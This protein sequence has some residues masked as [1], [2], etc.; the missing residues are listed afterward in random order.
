[1]LR[2]HVLDPACGSG[3]FLYVAYR[4][5]KRLELELLEKIHDNFGDR[6]RE[7]AGGA[8]L[9][10]ASQFFGLDIK[11]FAVELA[12]VTLMIAKK[13]APGGSRA[14]LA[15]DEQHRTV[16]IAEPELPL[17]N[18]NA[19]I[20]CDDALFCPWPAADAVI[21]N[22]PYLGSRYVA[23]EHGY[24][25]ARR[26]YAAFPDVPKMADYC[27]YWFRRAHDELPD[28]GRAGLVGTNT[29]RQ[30]ESREASLDYVVSNGGAITEAVSTE[31][32]SGDAAGPRL[33]RQLVK[34]QAGGGKAVVHA[35]RRLSRQPVESGGVR[36]HRTLAAKWNRCH[37][38]SPNRN[39]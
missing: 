26:I 35:N 21:G 33:H 31:V 30:N 29:I 4:E 17:D 1:M 39:Q 2:Y 13:L 19:N 37:R 5:L 6:T 16:D 20:R 22:P 12:K 9:V 32:W 36:L 27:V 11:P 3:N 14:R 38:R 28:G 15:T 8:L 18:L 34:G 23:K 7:Q 10:S 25:Y 24:E